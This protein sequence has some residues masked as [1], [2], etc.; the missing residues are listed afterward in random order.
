[1]LFHAAFPVFLS[2]FQ[3]K[4]IFP[5]SQTLGLQENDSL[6]IIENRQIEKQTTWF[7]SQ[8]SHNLFLFLLLFPH[9]GTRPIQTRVLVTLRLAI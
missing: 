2:V 4:S 6:H 5:P 7:F 3:A 8:T 1:M 9:T